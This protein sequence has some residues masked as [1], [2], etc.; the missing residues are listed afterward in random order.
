M[1]SRLTA[2]KSASLCGK[3]NT[4]LLCTPKVLLDLSSD[5]TPMTDDREKNT[6]PPTSRN[7]EG[8]RNRPPH[9]D[10][11]VEGQSVCEDGC[12]YLLYLHGDQSYD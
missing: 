1:F 7:P 5:I 4:I 6:A 11:G 10:H 3:N 9:Q 2:A 8:K 12:V